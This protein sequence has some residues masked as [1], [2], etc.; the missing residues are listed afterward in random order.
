MVS[1]IVT[2]GHRDLKSGTQGHTGHRLLET[3]T[4]S[5][6]PALLGFQGIVENAYVCIISASKWPTVTKFAPRV[7]LAGMQ[8]LP[9]I[10]PT[11][12]GQR[13]HNEQK[14]IVGQP[15]WHKS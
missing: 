15:E 11:F 10:W 2:A 7:H 14:N 4:R 5:P 1:Q 6:W 8:Q 13:A 9:G 3:K 12:R